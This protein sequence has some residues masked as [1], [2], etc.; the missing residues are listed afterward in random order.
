MGGP[1]S[2][3]VPVRGTVCEPS[4]F[5][6]SAEGFTSGF[7]SAGP[8]VILLTN[9]TYGLAGETFSPT[10]AS[11]LLPGE[12]ARSTTLSFTEIGETTTFVPSSLSPSDNKLAST[13]TRPSICFI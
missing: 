2:G 1:P 11:S 7:E 8:V 5:V 13:S 4:A 6:T 10:G 12:T 9:E 3:N